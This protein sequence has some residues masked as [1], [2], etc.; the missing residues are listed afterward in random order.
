MI[1]SA[2]ISL[3]IWE[4]AVD[5]FG[6]RF[7]SYE[8]KMQEIYKSVKEAFK[9]HAQSIRADAIIGLSID[10]G[11]ISRKGSQM[12]ISSIMIM[13][14]LRQFKNNAVLFRNLWSLV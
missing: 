11:E 4:R 2:P 5:F 9:Q 14:L 10:I 3:A 12:F 7:T 6:G 1:L 13:Y 8:K